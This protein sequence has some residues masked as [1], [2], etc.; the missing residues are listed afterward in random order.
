VNRDATQL[1][2]DTEGRTRRDLTVP[3]MG[4]MA[5]AGIEPPRFSFIFDAPANTS[6]TLD[7]NT[8]TV[9]KSNG[10]AF[11]IA[12]TSKVAAAGGGVVALNGV[13]G[14]RRVSTGVVGATRM[15][16]RSGDD[17]KTESLGKRNI[18]G[19]MAEGTRTTTVIPA[20]QIG[21]ELPI[22]IVSERWYSPE[23]QMIV[24][25]THRDPRQGETTYKLTNIRRSE[26][27]KS[28]FEVPADYKVAE[29]P[30]RLE[31]KIAPP[32]Q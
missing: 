15:I 8:K 25:S 1:A 32:K 22:Q 13:E 24:L 12:I 29:F 17:G 19:V 14:E 11:N 20:G 26:P 5:A 10:R 27:V 16:E 18:E 6:Y 4:P 30:N 21:N 31:Y 2:R 7:H 9:R 28:L 23:L 3:L